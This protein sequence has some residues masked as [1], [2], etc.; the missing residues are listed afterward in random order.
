MWPCH[1]DI[2]RVSLILTQ[3]I[4][5][6]PQSKGRGMMEVSSSSSWGLSHRRNMSTHSGQAVSYQIITYRKCAVESNLLFPDSSALFI[7]SDGCDHGCRGRT[8]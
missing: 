4:T 3:H 6:C 8:R 2:F 7:F 5:L 1:D